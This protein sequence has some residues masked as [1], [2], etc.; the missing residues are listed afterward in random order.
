[1]KPSAFDIETPAWVKDGRQPVWGTCP[2]APAQT[3]VSVQI[4]LPQSSLAGNAVQTATAEVRDASG[5]LLDV[6]VT[7]SI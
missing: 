7:W 2:K 6:P 4:A 1:M 5:A 3:T